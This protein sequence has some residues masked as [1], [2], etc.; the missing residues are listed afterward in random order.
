M[1]EKRTNTGAGRKRLSL[2]DRS[3]DA[4]ARKYPGFTIYESTQRVAYAIG[5]LA[6]YRAA[7]R[8]KR[9]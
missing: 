7:K 2:F 8:E 1:M 9:K 3:M 5:Y 4:A 6:G